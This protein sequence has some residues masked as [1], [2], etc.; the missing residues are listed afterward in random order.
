MEIAKKLEVSNALREALE[1]AQPDTRICSGIESDGRAVLSPSAVLLVFNARNSPTLEYFKQR[2]EALQA[3][4]C[5]ETDAY[6]EWKQ[7]GVRLVQQTYD[8]LEQIPGLMVV[9][10]AK[11]G[12]PAALVIGNAGAIMQALA[13]PDVKRAG[14]AVASP[15]GDKIGL[16]DKGTL[17]SLV[18]SSFPKA[19][20]DTPEAVKENQEALDAL[21]DQYLASNRYKPSVEGMGL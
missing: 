3:K 17:E 15:V 4:A 9:S 16:L 8:K 6:Q 19:K 20:G 7:Q 12:I 10:D 21:F 18:R 13:L 14:F 5:G 11:A 2:K 1:K